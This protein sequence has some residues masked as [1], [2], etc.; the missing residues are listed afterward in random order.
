MDAAGFENL[1][2]KQLALDVSRGDLIPNALQHFA[3]NQIGQ[4][5]TLAIELQMEPIRLRIRNA[6]KI[7]D[8]HT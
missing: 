5:K 3:Q 8:P 6:L 4:P 1:Q 7:V 2:P